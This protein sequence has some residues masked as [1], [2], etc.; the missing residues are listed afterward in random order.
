M[1]L[2]CWQETELDG[3]VSQIPYTS[4]GARGYAA[5]AAAPTVTTTT[6]THQT[7]DSDI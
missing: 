4:E 3:S 5:A 2:K 6:T 1:K 7:S